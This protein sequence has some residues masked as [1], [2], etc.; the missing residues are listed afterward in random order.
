MKIQYYVITYNWNVYRIIIFYYC[1]LMTVILF[2]I[3]LYLVHVY[4]YLPAHFGGTFNSL[5]LSNDKIQHVKFAG[6]TT[7]QGSLW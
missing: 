4:R 7:S 3:L 5:M 2:L 1:D 6:S